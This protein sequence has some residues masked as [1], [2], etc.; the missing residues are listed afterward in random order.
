LEY[1]FNNLT[2]DTFISDHLSESIPAV[3][4]KIA[5][6]WPAKTKWFEDNYL[7]NLISNKAIN[8]SKVNSNSLSNPIILTNY[9]YKAYIEELINKTNDYYWDDLFPQELISDIEIP[10]F[11]NILYLNNTRIWKV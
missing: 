4:R 11:T 1:F 6:N 3:I 7:I 8:V 9:T 10:I 2:I 5:N